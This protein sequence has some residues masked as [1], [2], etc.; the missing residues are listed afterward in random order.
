MTESPRASE[1]EKCSEA[2]DFAGGMDGFELVR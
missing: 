2:F 1:L